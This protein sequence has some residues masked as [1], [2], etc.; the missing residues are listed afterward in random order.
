MDVRVI[1]GELQHKLLKVVFDRRWLKNARSSCAKKEYCTTVW[2]LLNEDI[3][4]KFSEKMEVFYEKCDE[5]NAWLKYKS[6][7]LKAAEK[8]CGMGKGMPQHGETWWWNQ[9]VQKAISEKRK[10]FQRWKQ[11]PSAENKSCYLSDKKKAKRAVAEAMKNEAV[12][13]MEEIR[14]DRNVVLRRMRMMKKEANDLAGNN[15][16][17][18]ENGNIVYAEDG[19]KRVWKE[20]MEAIM[21]EENPWD[22]MVNVEVVEGPMEPFAMNEVERALGIIKNGKAS[23][24]T[25]IVKEHLAASPHGKQVILQI[26]NEVLDGMD[27]P[28]DWRMSTVVPIYKKKGS[29]MDCA[30]YRG[31]KLL[32]HRMK[33]A[34]RLLEKRLRRLVKVDQMQFGFMPSRSTVDAIFI[35]RRMQESYLEKNRKLFVDLEKAF[36]RVPR[37]VISS[38]SNVDVK[39]SKN[40]G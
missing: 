36:D 34:E 11:L 9:D 33:V 2:K 12:K 35:L 18:D 39:R 5:Q 19:R 26:A 22:R 20:H 40:A 28:H 31:V 10:S 27:M 3:K 13:E 6:S 1:G 15:C 16:I 14:N 25:E 37:K 8:V 24:P 29:V 21:N 38:G 4:T 30:S 17:K 7:V 32:E 23:G